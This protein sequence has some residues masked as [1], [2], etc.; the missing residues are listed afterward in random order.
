M[1]HL[2]EAESKA[3]ESRI[4]VICQTEFLAGVLTVCGHQFCKECITLWFKAHR[5]CPVCKRKLTLDNLHDITLKRQALKVT[6]EHGDSNG[7]GV[8]NGDGVDDE[9]SEREQNGQQKQLSGSKKANIY[10]AFSTEKLEEIKNIDLPGPSFTTKVD[11]IVRHL[12][13]LRSTDPGAKSIVFSQY[14]AFLSILAEAFRRYR[15]AFSR[16]TDRNGIERFKDDP[17]I[18]CFLLHARAHAS[19][20]NL[21]NAS[22]VLLCEPLLNTAIELQAIA[23]VHRI[24]QK[25]E[26]TVWLYIVDGTVEESI[27][28]LSVKRRIAHM[29]RGGGGSGSD[30]NNLLQ[31]T[32]GINGKGKDK[33]KGKNKAGDSGTET[34]EFLDSNLEL[35]NSLEMQQAQ[36][37]KL[38]SKGKMAGEE[39]A[40]GDLWT[41]LFGNVSSSS[42]QAQAAE[43]EDRLRNDLVVRRYLAASAAEERQQKNHQ[44]G[45]SSGSA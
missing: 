24:G 19:G 28:D 27:Y 4:C 26:T 38:M 8:A 35:A 23:R 37:S 34:P 29:S 30:G 14:P 43:N 12:L 15:I 39:V 22:H 1:V 10:A 11:T 7:V 31:N 20:L 41:C 36:L 2:K 17:T 18:E 44:N 25:H 9:Q 32:N 45:E 16:Y 3:D 13:W 6:G 21:V 40:K 5:N 33:D 42:A